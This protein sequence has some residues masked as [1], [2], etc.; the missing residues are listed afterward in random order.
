MNLSNPASLAKGNAAAYTDAL[1]AEL[2]EREP[3]AVLDELLP[4]LLSSLDG[5][6]AQLLAQPERPGKWSILGVL[7][8][9]V[10]TE[11][12]YAYRVRLILTVDRPVLQGYDQDA[13]AAGLRYDQGD[14]E[15]LLEELGALRRRSLRL[16][17]SLTPAELERSGLHT[18]RGPESVGFIAR[19]LAAHDLVHRAQIER[20]KRTIGID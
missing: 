18:E 11:I 10:D 8:H 4:E 1:L 19:L 14:P 5:P 6:S 16:L 7:N 2:G 17:R 3:L 20:I 12:V 9:L 13:W 15:D